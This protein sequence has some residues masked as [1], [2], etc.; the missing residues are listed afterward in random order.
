MPKANP[1]HKKKLKNDTVMGVKAAKENCHVEGCI[2][3]AQ[4]HLSLTNLSEYLSKLN[5]NLSTANKSKARVALCKKHYKKY[6]KLADD[7]EKFSRFKDFGSKKR[8]KQGK[9]HYF[10]E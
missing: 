5:W 1:K 4:H 7:N 2:S 10:L 8:E 9:A 3:D 6:K